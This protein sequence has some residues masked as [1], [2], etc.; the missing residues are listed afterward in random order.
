MVNDTFGCVIDD[1][2]PGIL[3][4]LPM[5]TQTTPFNPVPLRA[6]FP[7]LQLQVK[8]Q[9]AVFLDGPGGTQVPQSV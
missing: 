8:G 4:N 6:Q 7:A 5:S 9:T 3:Y 1:S 2:Q